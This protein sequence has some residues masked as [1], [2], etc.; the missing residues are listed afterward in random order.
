MNLHYFGSV[1][2]QTQGLPKPPPERV[3][4]ITF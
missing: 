3:G 1:S 2:S 4:G